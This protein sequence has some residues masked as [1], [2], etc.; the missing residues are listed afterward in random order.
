MLFS[1]KH[2][3][4]PYV[5]CT[6]FNPLLVLI[7]LNCN[8][9]NM[10]VL[11]SYFLFPFCCLSLCWLCT[12]ILLFCL[13]VSQIYIRHDLCMSAY[14]CAMERT[15]RYTLINRTMFSST[16]T[17]GRAVPRLCYELP[18]ACVLFS[19]SHYRTRSLFGSILLSSDSVSLTALT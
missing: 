11:G 4:P 12:Y 9:H 14:I 6:T 3:S 2:P 7:F 19:F 5:F 8:I 16:S 15:I 17:K 1:N 10:W 13:R 18:F